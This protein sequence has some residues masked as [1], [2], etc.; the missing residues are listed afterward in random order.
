MEKDYGE[1]EKLYEE[2]KEEH[3]DK[4]NEMIMKIQAK[5]D[6]LHLMEKNRKK[7]VGEK[8]EFWQKYE[9]E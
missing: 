1:L 4:C 9:A 5:N 2:L 7:I 6:E 8:K 3:A